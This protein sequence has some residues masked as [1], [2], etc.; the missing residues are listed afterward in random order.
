MFNFLVEHHSQLND[1]FNF[2]VA[3]KEEKKVKE[4]CQRKST[5]NSTLHFLP[6]Q[7]FDRPTLPPN[8]WKCGSFMF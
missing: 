7:Q 8:S 5:R 6:F 4:E 2:A 1:G 3:L